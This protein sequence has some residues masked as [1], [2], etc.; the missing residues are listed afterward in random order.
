V[1]ESDDWKT[2]MPALDRDTRLPALCCAWTKSTAAHS[3]VVNAEHEADQNDHSQWIYLEEIRKPKEQIL[4]WAASTSQGDV[5]RVLAENGQ[6]LTESQQRE[7]VQK[8]LVD[9]R[10]QKKE[11]AET[12]HDYQQIDDFLELL[13]IAF[14]WT[15]TGA[16]A[17]TTTLHFEPARNF[18]PPTRE[19]RVFSSMTGDLT[20][21][22]EQHRVR[23]VRGHLFHDV[24]F[25]GGILGR[26]R[27]GSSFSL[28]QE[29]VVPS[30]WELTAIHVHLEGSAL[31]FKS[32]SLQEDDERSGFELEPS[33][34]TLDQAATRVMTEPEILP[35]PPSSEAAP[36]TH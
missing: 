1:G 20:A 18:H 23:S 3:A 2:G 22:N 14:V 19:A 34:I 21:D 25:G 16:P 9:V 29:Q 35:P 28:E 36:N 7:R 12:N 11:V 8:F 4:Q 33:T 5:E 17:T 24:T 13:P 30:F 6:K 32:V 27:E 31:L 10:A 15:E 26:L